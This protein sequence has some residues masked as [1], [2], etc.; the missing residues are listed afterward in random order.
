MSTNKLEEYLFSQVIYYHSFN[1]ISILSQLLNKILPSLTPWNN[2][3]LR[4]ILV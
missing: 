1:I 3:Y 2:T 4:A